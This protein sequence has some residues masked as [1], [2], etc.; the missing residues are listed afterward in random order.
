[1]LDNMLDALKKTPELLTIYETLKTTLQERYPA[2]VIAC[3]ASQIA[4]VHD[5]LPYLVVTLPHRKK[6]GQE[7][8]LILSVFLSK[9]L[10]NPRFVQITEPYANVWLHH[11]FLH[12][13]QDLDTDILQWIDLAY[14][15]NE[16]TSI[17]KITHV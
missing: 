1:M 14:R 16:L 17:P 12:C 3:Q 4:F 8:Y 11:L 13:V 7:P 6:A 2:T 5:E 9:R 10:D 15:E